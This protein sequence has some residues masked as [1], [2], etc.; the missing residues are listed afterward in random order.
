VAQPILFTLPAAQPSVRG[1]TIT[2]LAHASVLIACGHEVLLTDPWLSEKGGFPGYYMGESL[3]MGLAELPPLTG[4]LA[5]MDH[6]DHFDIATFAGYRDHTV[7]VVVPAGTAMGESARKAGFTNVRDLSPWG[8]TQLGSFHITAVSTKP[9]LP[10]GHFEYE[11][12]SVIEV[13]GQT[14]LFCAHTMM[15]AVQAAVAERFP[16]IDVAILAINGLCLRFRG[17]HQLS[18]APTDAARLLG[19]L[20]ARIAIPIHYAF[21]GGL[22]SRAVLLSHRGT[23]EGL[24]DAARD[25]APE[26]TVMTLAPGQQLDIAWGREGEAAAVSD[27]QKQQHL[28][29]F[30]DKLNAR[31]LSA[32][33]LFSSDFVHHQPLAT[34]PDTSREGARAGMKRLQEAI[35]DFRVC[36]DRIV[37]EGDAAIVRVLQS[38][39]LARAIPG[40]GAPGPMNTRTTM[41]Y[42]F[43]GSQI[44]EEWIDGSALT[45]IQQT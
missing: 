19:R 14:I 12:A 44:A 26:T 13:G 33:D 1:L 36:V 9:D 25:L 15:P 28:L 11:H 38:G 40:L 10:T 21:H 37:I 20:G 8:T 22:A 43:S 24:A 42:R 7:P 27:A 35:P 32:F 4:V 3:P 17:N 45:P 41:L 6:Y 23:P 34:A 16:R 29:R 2:R 31:D 30:F 5:S 18:L 39:T